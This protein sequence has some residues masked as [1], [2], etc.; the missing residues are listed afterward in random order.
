MIDLKN[1]KFYSQHKQD[2][3][4]IDYF[5]GK[6]DG[7]FLDIGAHDG[8]TLSNTYTLETELDWSGICFEPMPHEFKK[9]SGKT[10]NEVGVVILFGTGT[11]ALFADILL[12]IFA[13]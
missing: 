9:L 13:G 2:E 7:T 12:R 11:M 5:K 4:I 1:M 6:K 8:I 3:F 10:L